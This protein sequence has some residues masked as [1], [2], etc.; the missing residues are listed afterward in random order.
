MPEFS[1]VFIFDTNAFINRPDVLDLLDSSILCVLPGTV[2][3]ELAKKRAY[4]EDGS[5]MATRT[6]DALGRIASQPNIVLA[7]FRETEDMAALRELLGDGEVESRVVNDDIIL[8]A[9]IRL[10]HLKPVLVT[11]DGDMRLKA[12]RV[13]ITS[14][15]LQEYLR[16]IEKKETF[17]L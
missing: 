10:R 11:N 2:I 1:S 16:R 15:R 3:D 17:P 8:V 6:E 5:T 4:A 7:D 9:A 12:A 14:W 13:G